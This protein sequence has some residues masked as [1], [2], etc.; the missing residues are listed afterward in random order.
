MDAFQYILFSTF[1]QA[2]WMSRAQSYA[3]APAHPTI[4]A[5]P[6]QHFLLEERQND[7]GYV[8]CSHA[9]RTCIFES[10]GVNEGCFDSTLSVFPFVTHCYAYPNTWEGTSTPAN[11]IFCPSSA[12]ACGEYVFTN[13]A[14]AWTNLGCSSTSYFFTAFQVAA[15]SDSRVS[16]APITEVVLVTAT[17]TPA[18]IAPATTSTS[19]SLSPSSTTPPPTS[20]TTTPP[21]SQPTGGDSTVSNAATIGG[22]VGG[23]VGGLGALVGG[24]ATWYYLRKKH[25][26]KKQQHAQQQAFAKAEGSPGMASPPLATPYC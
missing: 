21:S 23:G 7:N 11:E 13:A 10:G 24:L 5:A 25:N 2:L 26:L 20:M 9:G 16:T 6:A 18:P 8:T 3:L 14:G 12:P 15:F 1:L 22:A 19:P 17:S 4:T